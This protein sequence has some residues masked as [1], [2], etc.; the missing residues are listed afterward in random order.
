MEGRAR[1]RRHGD[2]GEGLGGRRSDDWR[3]RLGGRRLGDLGAGLGG[4][5]VMGGKELGGRGVLQG[6][7]WEKEAWL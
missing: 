3:D 4:G 5:V 1:R 6:R 2:L 7:Y